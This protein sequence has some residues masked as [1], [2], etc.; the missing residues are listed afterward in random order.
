MDKMATPVRGRS[1]QAKHAEGSNDLGIDRTRLAYERTLL[2]L[3]RT[4]NSLI[5]FG[6]A[7]QQLSFGSARKTESLEPEFRSRLHTDD[8]V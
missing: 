2:S 3:I 6:F 4:A 8:V 1:E 5:A 7:I